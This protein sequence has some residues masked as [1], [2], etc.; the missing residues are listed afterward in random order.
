[1]PS[2]SPSTSD[3]AVIVY[4]GSTSVGATCIQL[5]KAAGAM[6]Y[7]TAS[8][9]NHEYCK[10]L[11]ADKVFDYRDSDWVQQAAAAMKDKTVVGAYDSISTDDT[12]KAT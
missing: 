10:A 11:G 3:K 1:M 7:A 4:G 9:S 5:A 6:V 2:V 12:A 8:K